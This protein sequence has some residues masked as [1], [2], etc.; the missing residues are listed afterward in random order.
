MAVEFVDG[1]WLVTVP[2][3]PEVVEA[4]SWYEAW[5]LA[6]RSRPR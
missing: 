1:V 6:V 4:S 2:W 3:L 5:E